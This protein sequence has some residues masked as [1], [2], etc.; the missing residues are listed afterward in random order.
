[1]VLF[2]LLCRI[3]DGLMLSESMDRLEPSL[4]KFIEQGKS[5]IKRLS[6]V[7]DKAC[8][9]EASDSRYYFAY[10]IENDVCYLT[11]CEKS[12]PKKLAFKFLEEI[13]KE[14]DT[15]Y[16]FE[17][18][19]AKRPYQFVKFESFITKTK[20]VY[21]DTRSQKNLSDISVE[22]R[23]VHK[24]MSKN[25]KDIVGR[26]EKLNDVNDKSEILLAESIKYEKET[27]KLQSQLFLKKYGPILILFLFVLI[28]YFKFYY[29]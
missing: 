10:L 11:F 3:S 28:I 25:I 1:M 8:T 18:P 13:Y 15:S 19:L 26:G 29:F 22:L 27:V 14:F 20:N 12:Y 7:S 5:I 16:G 4:D 17:V 23:D 24:I 2:A 21:I 6:R 9:I